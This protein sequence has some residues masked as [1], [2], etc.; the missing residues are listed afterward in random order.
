MPRIG[1]S[2]RLTKV[3]CPICGKE[4]I[5]ESLLGFNCCNRRFS[6]ETYKVEEIASPK[7]VLL[8]PKFLAK[9]RVKQPDG[10][11]KTVILRPKQEG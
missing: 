9:I 3:K 10:S 8:K 11:V 1:V 4:K 7:Y 5:T 2:K 6:V